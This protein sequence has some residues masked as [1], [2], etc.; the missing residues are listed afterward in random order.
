[1]MGLQVMGYDDKKGKER[2]D[3][4]KKKYHIVVPNKHR[5]VDELLYMNTF[6]N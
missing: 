5:L 3:S 1:M 6:E 4:G 2:Q